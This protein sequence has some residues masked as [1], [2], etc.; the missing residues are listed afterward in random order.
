MTAQSDKTYYFIVTLD[1]HKDGG[2]RG[3]RYWFDGTPMAIHA[4]MVEANDSAEIWREWHPTVEV[5]RVYR[6]GW[7]WRE[8]PN[9]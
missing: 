6:E 8:D 1:H 9:V 2:Q 4:D 5:V 3:R 7:A